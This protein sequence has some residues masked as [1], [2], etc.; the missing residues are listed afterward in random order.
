MAHILIIDDD[1]EVCRMLTAAIGRMGHEAG[2]ALT[3]ESGLAKN[4]KHS[5]DVVFLDV[6]LP[7]GNGLQAIPEIKESPTLPEV[8]IITGKG[9]ADGAELAIKSGVWDYI[10]KSP[11]LKELR[12]QLSRVVQ[13]RQ[14]KT[15]KKQRL[16]DRKDIIGN[17]PLISQ[18]L[19][20][21]SQAAGT[22]AN[23]LICGETGTGKELF[24][25]AIHR[26]SSRQE[27][28]F[29]V[30][31]C[32]TLPETLV[33]SILFGHAKGAYTGADLARQGL[34][35]QA[36]GGTLFL[37]EVGELPTATQKAFLRV[38]QERRFRPVGSRKE[39]ESNFR[40][41]SATNRNL[42]DMVAK[43]QFRQDL[44]FRLRSSTIVLPPLRKRD[45]DIIELA[46]HY[47]TRF[48]A[49]NQSGTK[50]FSQEFMEALKAYRWPGNVREL[51]N[52]IESALIEAGSEPTLIPRHLPV[53]I[54][55]E[56]AR[57]SFGSTGQHQAKPIYLKG[58]GTPGPFKEYKLAVME[59]AEKRYLQDLL[60]A[61]NHNIK[62][63]C[64]IAELSRARL[65]ALLKKH[66]VSGH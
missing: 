4:R 38:L 23:V 32:A 3:L 58:S 15:A 56:L 61:A 46:V 49:R 45:D 9:D 48:T 24:A 14:E 13:Y 5:Y 60:T 62:K 20:I 66:D 27:R 8:I 31:D 37:D 41:I 39:R 21:V 34:V 16:L 40:L 33:E 57:S 65:Y 25:H 59:A 6:N 53:N 7:D 30:V 47:A 54:R 43:S 26:N 19:E 22:D 12:L 64:Q 1:V 10:E 11:S 35:S 29:V 42:D 2:Y 28:D 50:G 18:S 51:A 52:C 55:V 44:L 63:A 17:S 36:D